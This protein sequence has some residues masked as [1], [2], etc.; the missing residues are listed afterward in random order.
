M[1]IY[2]QRFSDDFGQEQESFY[3]SIEESIEKQKQR[4]NTD[5]LPKLHSSD[6]E[7]EVFFHRVVG[8]ILYIFGK[9]H[10]TA[11]EILAYYE[12]I[13]A[14]LSENIETPHQFVFVPEFADMQMYVYNPTE[15]TLTL[16]DPAQEQSAET[17]ASAKISSETLQEAAPETPANTGEN[18][19]AREYYD[20]ETGIKVD[21]SGE[22]PV[23]TKGEDGGEPLDSR[24]VYAL[25]RAR[26]EADDPRFA[27][28][29][30]LRT[31]TD[32][33]SKDHTKKILF[34][35]PQPKR[36]RFTVF[37]YVI[38]TG[39]NV[40]FSGDKPVFSA[41]THPVSSSDAYTHI[42]QKLREQNPQYLSYFNKVQYQ[43]EEDRQKIT[44]FIKTPS[45]QLR[46]IEY[47]F[48]SRKPPESPH[49]KYLGQVASIEAEVSAAE[50]IRL[51]S[52]PSP[53][54]PDYQLGQGVGKNTYAQ[55]IKLI[56]IGYGNADHS[57]WVLV[58]IKGEN[59]NTQTG[60]IEGRY[61]Q[62]HLPDAQAIFTRR[63]HEVQKGETL[64]KILMQ[65]YG[66]TYNLEVGNDLR[67]IAEAFA[68]LNQDN[69]GVYYTKD[70][71]S[72][73]DF[74]DPAM[75]D[76][77]RVY[78]AIRIK[79]DHTIRLPS[80][81]YINDLK[82][83]GKLS[84]R[85][86]LHN[87][88]IEWG[89]GSIGFLKGFN[90]G[91][92]KGA[93]DT[94][95]GVVKL[96]YQLITGELYAMFKKLLSM[97]WEEIKQLFG[98][99]WSDF[100]KKW[101]HPNPHDRWFFRGEVLGQVAFEI[102]LAVLTAGGGLAKNL[103][104]VEKLVPILN[105]FNGMKKAIATATKTQADE[106]IGKIRQAAA[107]RKNEIVRLSSK[108]IQ[109]LRK[110]AVDQLL[111]HGG[112]VYSNPFFD[113][114]Y[115]RKLI[116]VMY[117][118]SLEGA[119]TFGEFVAKANDEVRQLLTKAKDHWDEAEKWFNYVK[120]QADANTGHHKA[121]SEALNTLWKRYEMAAQKVLSQ[122]PKLTNAG[123]TAADVV[124]LGKLI[125]GNVGAKRIMGKHKLMDW[126][127][128]LEKLKLKPDELK[129]VIEGLKS[130]DSQTLMG[131]L[132]RLRVCQ[133]QGWKN[134]DKLELG[135]GK[136]T[137]YFDNTS[138]TWKSGYERYIDIV[139][140]GNKYIE[141]KY[142]GNLL[143]KEVGE[144]NKFLTQIQKDLKVLK[145]EPFHYHFAQ[146]KGIPNQQA[147][148]Q[149]IKQVLTD[150]AYRNKTS[151]GVEIWKNSLNKQ[152]KPYHSVDE[153][154]TDKF[155]LIKLD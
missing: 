36:T 47:V 51:H 98:A 131:E 109:V 14:E 27:Q 49:Q 116:P 65:E 141:V 133:Q 153:F 114:D 71:G 70:G 99:L 138:N 53:Q 30:P 13:L 54:D 11:S 59:G 147:L 23:F 122:T 120:K 130:N 89:K 103:A 43:D 38:Y 145:N 22:I 86:N 128:E 74:F 106:L 124:K 115:L 104:K 110:E 88:A 31:T 45:G 126:I 100:K 94:V 28:H 19:K 67:T 64:E 68:N 72:W 129:R 16:K 81:Q 57:G 123:L 4:Y 111:K 6:E 84:Q 15:Q 63:K 78:Q 41:G 9:D 118:S 150:G 83:S 90:Y 62:E 37:E 125:M 73:R 152:N 80:L 25:I 61:V 148:H 91:L 18:T 151:K 52:T 95:A 26:K 76:A 60:W 107:K 139:K 149:Q 112:R 44:F 50:G 105:K 75:A 33:D 108:E 117:Y 5:H 56:I 69:P 132:F 46:E 140:V 12:S 29:F 24:E 20:V 85:S 10:N 42:A 137:K 134:V 55:G 3:T 66:G 143:Q 79:A 48:P 40:D 135:V 136:T 96:I 101:N 34:K 146:T 92:L 1:P 144:V 102:A 93:Y 155:K 39:L 77:R 58:E 21:F 82:K 142:Y 121:T 35:I 127:K 113:P 97:S 87:L 119:K 17:G 8:G 2:D 154:I 7:G 32:Q